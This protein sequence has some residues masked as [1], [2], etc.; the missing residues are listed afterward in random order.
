[1]HLSEK[2]NAHSSAEPRGP[3]GGPAPYHSLAPSTRCPPY[4]AATHVRQGIDML[5]WHVGCGVALPSRTLPTATAGVPA[6]AHDPCS[7]NRQQRS[8]ETPRPRH[9]SAKRALQAVTAH[10]LTLDRP[11]LSLLCLSGSRMC[12]R[13][14]DILGPGIRATSGLAR[15]L[16][17]CIRLP[18]AQHP[19]FCYCPAEG[20]T[21][22]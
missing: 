16:A 14:A 6:A 2:P 10:K 15:H 3:Q 22:G 9:S 7:R 13:S 8:T 21:L 20:S 11:L 17:F 4:P 18:C 5:H 1:M 19:G 12:S